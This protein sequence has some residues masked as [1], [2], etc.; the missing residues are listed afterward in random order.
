VDVEALLTNWYLADLLPKETG[1][2][3]VERI[4]AIAD[5]LAKHGKPVETVVKLHKVRTKLLA[6]ARYKN[7]V[8]SSLLNP[9]TD[10]ALISETV[11]QLDSL[12]KA[13]GV[14]KGSEIDGEE[15][16]RRAEKA[17]DAREKARNKAGPYGSQKGNCTH[18]GAEGHFRRECKAYAAGVPQTAEG[19]EAW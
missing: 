8:E 3:F 14:S 13:A 5:D 9:H 17:R 1:T 4:G 18:C 7:L 12:R 11:G 6:D 2:E 19:K 15:K 10:F 16:A